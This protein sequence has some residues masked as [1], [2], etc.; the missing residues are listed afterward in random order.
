M[1]LLIV[2]PL[3]Y[4]SPCGAI[5][6]VSIDDVCSMPHKQV[7]RDEPRTLRQEVFKE[8]GIVNPRPEDYEI[9]YLIAPLT[10]EASASRGAVI[11]T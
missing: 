6:Q 7:V 3:E 11:S 8:Y 5:R 10:R 4:S 9:D 2:S 1:I